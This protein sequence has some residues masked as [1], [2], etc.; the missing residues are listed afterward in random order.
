MPERWPPPA[1]TSPPDHC[2]P[3][4][5]GRHATYDVGP[6]QALTELTDVP[7]LALQAGDVVNIHY[8]PAPYRTKFGLRAQGTADAP[9]IINGVTSNTC[10]RPVISGEQA[11]TARDARMADFNRSPEGAGLI[12]IHR[13]PEGASETFTPRHIIIQNLKLTGVRGGKGFF[14]E[15]GKVQNYA[16]FSAAIYALRVHN[17]TVQNCEITGN[18]MGIFVDTKGDAP[19]EYS[20]NIIIRGNLIYYN[21]NPGSYYEHNLYI[22]ARRALYEGNFIGQA[23]GGGP[24]KD[25]SSG[26][27]IRYNKILARGHAMDLVES[28]EDV[29]ILRVDPLYP[30]AWVYGNII[31]NDSQAPAGMAVNMVHWGF[32]NA[33][34]R[35]RN[36]VLFFYHN[37]VVSRIEPQAFPYVVAFQIGR[38]GLA[39]Q[40]ATVEAAANVFWQQSDNEWRFLSQAGTLKFVGTNYV[41]PIWYPSKPGSPADVQKKAA[42][43]LAGSNPKLDANGLPLPGSPVLN[44]PDAG[45]SFTPPGA[46]AENLRVEHQ[47]KTGVGIVPRPASS[48]P[49]R[50][51]LGAMAAP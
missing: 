39:P 20:A 37:T 23:Y 10:A 43:M 17:L 21:G 28:E 5:I 13:P 7:W 50:T 24:L 30:Y 19:D 38:D 1:Q 35:G 41:P 11:V 22:Q 42:I 51:A 47:Y 8:R 45:P 3:R 46:I 48:K 40:G 14:N 27:V 49:G 15:A 34:E 9:V 44:Q 26:T 25:R 32:D 18:S 31:I 6:G 36:G 29:K 4:L 33:V 2:S 12:L 16:N